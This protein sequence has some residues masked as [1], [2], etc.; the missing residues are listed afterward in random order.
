MRIRALDSWGVIRWKRAGYWELGRAMQQVLEEEGSE[1]ALKCIRAVLHYD[2]AY[3]RQ[4]V[5]EWPDGVRELGLRVLDDP[6]RW[7]SGEEG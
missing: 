3:C 5:A 4:Q 7:T 2:E 6:H 1:A